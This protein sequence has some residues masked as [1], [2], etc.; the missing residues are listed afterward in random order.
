V[1]AVPQDEWEWFGHAAH[2]IVGSWC[3]FHLATK[4]GNYLVST[5]GEYI[6]PRHAN[7]SEQAEAKW[8]EDNWPG[9]DIGL[10]RKYETMVFL[11]GEECRSKKCGCGLPVPKEW[12]ELDFRGYNKAGEARAG[13]LEMCHKWS[14]KPL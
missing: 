8:I 7:G 10:D 13:H 14:N 9:E 1:K 11:A 5:V 3:R 12:S 6:H 4:V 2:L